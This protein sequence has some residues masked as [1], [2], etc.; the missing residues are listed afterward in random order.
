MPNPDMAM[1]VRVIT[2]TNSVKV[3]ETAFKLAEQRNKKVTV[4]HK[5]S[6]FKLGCGLFTESCRSVAEKFPNVEYREAHVDSIAA[7]LVMYPEH[8]DV[9]VTTN[10]FGDIL[11]DLASGLVGGLGMAPGLSVGPKYVMA[12]ATH[13]SAPDIAGKGIANPYALIMSG[14]MLFHW[15]G[16][17][18]NTSSLLHASKYIE[19]AVHST[20]KAKLVTPDLG[21]N[22][23]TKQMAEAVME[24]LPT[25]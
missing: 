9:L 21:G 13:G 4:V 23:S 6:V 12:Q 5:K 11:S 24:R 3:A 7:E 2:R 20:I 8:F 19:D 10:M 1:S 15:L 25:A 22:Y 17:K 14:M 16:T 18:T